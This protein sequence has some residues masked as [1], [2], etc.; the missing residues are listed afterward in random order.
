MNIKLGFREK[1][2]EK[3]GER[4]KEEERN[5]VEVKGGVFSPRLSGQEMGFFNL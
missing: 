1:A 2:G 3:G 5:W 4:E